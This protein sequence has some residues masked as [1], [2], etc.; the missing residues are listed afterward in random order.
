V[1]KSTEETI[2]ELLVIDC[3]MGRTEAFNLLASRW[4]K[5]LWYHAY[6]LVG[7]SDASWDITQ[8]TW[9]KIIKGLRKLK[10]PE[11]FRTWAYRITTNESIDWIKKSKRLKHFSIEEVQDPIDKKEKCID[12]KDLLQKLNTTK[13]AVLC[14]Y[15]FEQL[16]VT[17]ISIT[18]HI[19]KGTVKSRLHNARQELKKLWEEYVER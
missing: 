11:N 15:Y 8:Q 3:Q 14:L 17:E 18:L 10:R 13:R 16:S 7:D 4:Q 6:R 1:D 2:D 5:R 9:I 19:P 12:V